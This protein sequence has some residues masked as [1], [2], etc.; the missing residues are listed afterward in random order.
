V[1]LIRKIDEQI[2]QGCI[3]NDRRSQEILYRYFFPKLLAMCRRF[4]MDEDRQVSIINDGMLKVFTNIRQYQGIGSLEGWIRR[5]VFNCLSDH[6]RKDKNYIKG[7]LM[8]EKDMVFRPEALSKLYYEDIMV[9][10]E[11][12]PG[13]MQNVFKSYE[14]YGFSHKEIGETYQISE[15]TSKWHLSKA[16]ERLRVHFNGQLKAK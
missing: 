10:V 13:M 1:E 5:I 3:A 9:M 15:G 12:L 7:V 4:T 6:F 8:E 16:R 2:I 14:L 11:S